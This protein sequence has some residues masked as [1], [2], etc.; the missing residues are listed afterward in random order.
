[1]TVIANIPKVSCIV[2]ICGNMRLAK[3]V[4]IVLSPKL[5]M[6]LITI[7]SNVRLSDRLSFKVR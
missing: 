4:N 7:L 3:I 2:V 1:M 5:N 6:Q